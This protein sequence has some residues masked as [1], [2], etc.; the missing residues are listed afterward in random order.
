M[1]RGSTPSSPS[2]P[3]GGQQHQY[4][5]A[6]TRG[7]S[8]DLSLE[9]LDC[10]ANVLQTLQQDE[11]VLSEIEAHEHA[12]DVATEPDARTKLLKKIRRLVNQISAKTL[13]NKKALDEKVRKKEEKIKKA[14]RR[15]TMMSEDAKR[16]ESVALRQGR[17][18]AMASLCD[19]NDADLRELNLVPDG[20]TFH[21][22]QEP[23]AAL[24][25]GAGSLEDTKQ[26]VEAEPQTSDHGVCSP[27]PLGVSPGGMADESLSPNRTSR[28]ESLKRSRQSSC[29]R[30]EPSAASAEVAS[31]SVM[32]AE[33]CTEEHQ[34]ED[35]FS[36]CQHPD[37]KDSASR[38]AGV[39]L[40]RPRS[41]Y[42]C[43]IKFWSLHHFYDSLC[44]PCAA[45]NY[46][47][48]FQQPLLN[49]SYI[50]LVTGGRVKIGFHTALKL[51]NAGATVLVTSRFRND[52]LERF[53]NF[54]GKEQFFRQDPE[55]NNKSIADRLVLLGVDLRFLP[56]VE[57]LCDYVLENYDHLD[58]VIHNACQTIRRPQAYYEPLREKEQLSCADVVSQAMLAQ[59][60]AG[61]EDNID[62]IPSPHVQPSVP[63]STDAQQPPALLVDEDSLCPTQGVFYD[64]GRAA[65][66]KNELFLSPTGSSGSTTSTAVP[67][68]T[69]TSPEARNDGNRSAADSGRAGTTTSSS[70]CKSTTTTTTLASCYMDTA[71]TQQKDH[72]VS[73]SRSTRPSSPSEVEVD[74]DAQQQHAHLHLCVKDDAK[75]KLGSKDLPGYTDVNGQLIDYRDRHSWVFKLEEVETPEL[76]ECFLINAMAPFVMNGRLKPL[77]EKS[78]TGTHTRR[79]IVNVSAMEGKFYR[80]KTANHP[81][82]N[83][84]KAAL[85][86]MTKTSANDYAKNS[87]IFMNSVDTGWINDEKPVK[88]AFQHA[89]SS[90]WQT[91]IDEID[92][93]A[94]ILDPVFSWIYDV[95]GV[96]LADKAEGNNAS[97]SDKEK[98]AGSSGGAGAAGQKKQ[99]PPFGMFLKDYRETEW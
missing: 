42:V 7:T 23:L 58:G 81:H 30:D 84:A 50:F 48:R 79:F 31:G 28:S 5:E 73:A 2:R 22:F 37:D 55:N 3:A 85:N 24:A 8:M 15:Q 41:C 53:V 87:N 70:S 49:D 65:A 46:S 14:W 1:T 94:R 9:S 36:S 4:A 93:A 89:V 78:Q 51:L 64:Y 97:M 56:R 90:K 32:P 26:A 86:M 57:Q 47:K 17:L 33:S 76:V 67:S 66:L 38:A 11:T 39:Q 63:L 43:K 35:R 69:S 62:I 83:M 13:P 98:D 60:A 82:T 52:C 25:N 18:Q 19:V 99:Q 72:H 71:S 40:Q 95:N 45:L 68:S 12:T 27:A 96:C 61:G 75:V 16:M 10:C 80:Y 6:L 29:G 92:A 21:T 34:G 91:P 88:Q 20:A 77:L 44:P 74:L 59:G 54:Y